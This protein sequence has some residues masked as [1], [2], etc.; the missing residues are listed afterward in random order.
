M[1]GARMAY[2]GER[3]WAEG[4]KRPNAPNGMAYIHMTLLFMPW[5]V[6]EPGVRLERGEDTTLPMMDRP[7]HT[8]NVVRERGAPLRL[9]I[10]PETRALDG[11]GMGPAVHV[12]QRFTEVDGLRVPEDWSTFMN[13]EAI[14]HHAAMNVD[15]DGGFDASKLEMPAG[16]E[17]V[18]GR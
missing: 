13:G 18:G 2:D 16:A 14:G 4:W 15:L 9:F 7:S 6:Q 1:D 10:D 3:M 12:V 17:V 8:V 5:V 11:F